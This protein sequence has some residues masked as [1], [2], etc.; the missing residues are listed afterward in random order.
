[1]GVTLSIGEFFRNDFN[2]LPLINKKIIKKSN[3][4][5]HAHILVIQE[6]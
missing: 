4:F 2:R 3:S 1:M 5:T 6:L